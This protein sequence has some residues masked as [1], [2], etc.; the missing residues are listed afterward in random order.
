MNTHGTLEPKYNRQYK[1]SLFRILFSEKEELLSLYNAV[2]GT[3]YT[4]PEELV[5]NTLADVIYLSM[6]NDISFIIDGK[7]SLY[8]HQSTWNNNMPLRYLLY[9]GNLYAGLAGK[10]DLYTCRKII[11]PNPQFVVFYNGSK[12]VP[13]HSYQLLSESYREGQDAIEAAIIECIESNILAEFLRKHREE[14]C[15]VNIFEYD[16]EE[17]MSIVKEEAWE[18]GRDAGFADGRKEM[19]RQMVLE[20]IPHNTILS[21]AKITEEELEDILKEV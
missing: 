12:K 16:F 18:D 9:V 7:L 17:H 14:V 15:N 10:R 8:E 20:N 6:K 3:N 11:L 19:I 21:V 1:D 13:E 5:V 2:A 4:N